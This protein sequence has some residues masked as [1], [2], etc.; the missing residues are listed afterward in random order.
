MSKK[1][2]SPNQTENTFHQN[3]PR[4]YTEP[5]S[6][7]L[8]RKIRQNVPFNPDENNPPT[9]PMK[10]FSRFKKKGTKRKEATS[11]KLAVEQTAN[12]DNTADSPIRL[13][14][15][16]FTRFK[17]KSTKGIEPE[18]K[19]LSVEETGKPDISSDNTILL[20]VK[21][22]TRF[23]KKGTKRTEIKGKK[24][25]KEDRKEIECRH[26]SPPYSKPSRKIRPNV[27]GSGCSKPSYK[28]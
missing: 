21:Q 20:P 16:Q 1:S 25:L 19:K 14:V 8:S 13:P 28:L 11:E 23:K 17:K 27:R 7:K 18:S 24:A 2:N 15:K 22:F 3:S 26:P 6:S 9:P 4:P 12:P 5:P 10:K